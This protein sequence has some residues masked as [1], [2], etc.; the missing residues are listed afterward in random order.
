VGLTDEIA[1]FDSFI[2]LAEMIFIGIRPGMTFLLI[3]YSSHEIEYRIVSMFNLGSTKQKDCERATEA[4]FRPSSKQVKYMYDSLE[5]HNESG[6]W[7]LDRATW[8][9]LSSAHKITNIENKK[10]ELLQ[11]HPLN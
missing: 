11:E 5:A 6:R 10:R 2:R 9:S 1:P 8:W 3:P 4:A 7:D